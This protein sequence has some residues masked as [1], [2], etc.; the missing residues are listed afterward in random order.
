MVN[1]E[2][3]EEPF[4]YREI[5][6]EGRTMNVPFLRVR[7]GEEM[8][9]LHPFN[10]LVRTYDEPDNID[11]LEVRIDG[12]LQGIPMDE[13]TIQQ[14][15]EYNFPFRWDLHPDKNTVD[16]IAALAMKH[17]DSG[18]EELLDES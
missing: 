8:I 6:V 18:L 17:F 4:E 14:F 5:E 3:I 16:W 13:E 12:N 1:P 7:S 11:H 2:D 9:V 10:T 15:I